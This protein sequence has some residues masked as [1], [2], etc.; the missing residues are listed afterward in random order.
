MK[1]KSS[2]QGANMPCED[3]KPHM[4]HHCHNRLKE[5]F[6]HIPIK[7]KHYEL[8]DI[9]LV[10]NVLICPVQMPKLILIITAT[11]C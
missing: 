7:R 3:A 9:G 10:N 2:Q 4:D 1:Y 6:S 8:R 5:M 11:K